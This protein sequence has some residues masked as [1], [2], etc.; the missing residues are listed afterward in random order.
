MVDS[1]EMKFYT[2]TLICSYLIACLC[3]CIK[4]EVNLDADNFVSEVPFTLTASYGDP[5]TKLAFDEDGLGTTW[6]PG[7]K[8]YLVDVA[9]KNKTV[10]L[11]S[12]IKEPSKKASFKSESSVLSGDYVVLYGATSTSLYTSLEMT[13]DIKE[14]KNRLVLYG[15]L[16]V[17]DGQTSANISLSHAYAKLTFKFQN[18]P[19]G[20]T[21]MD[22]G[23]AAS[24]EGLNI[25]TS[26]TVSQSGIITANTRYTKI[27]SFGWAGKDL[28]YILLAPLM[29][30]SKMIYF[31]VNGKDANGNLITYEFVKDGKDLKPGHNYNII[32]NFENAS[33]KSI[34]KKSSVTKY[35]Y[36]LSSPAEFRAAA[37]LN[38]D[39]KNYSIESDVDFSNEVYF[40]ISAATMYGNK[41][42]LSNI[43]INL[44]KCD[45]VGVMSEGIANNLT[46]SNV[47]IKG[48]NFVGGIS[49]SS[50]DYANICHNAYSCI[51]HSINISGNEMVGGLY[52]QYRHEGAS[53]S[54]CEINGNSTIDG[55]MKVGGLI[56]SST[57]TMT[58]C[59]AKDNIAVKGSDSS[60]G[61]LVGTA[62]GDIDECCFEGTVSGNESVGGI[63]GLLYGNI[64]KSYVKGSVTGKS[65][66]IGG[67]IG[68]VS[69]DYS[70][71]NCYVIGDVIG[72]VTSSS[73]I[74]DS[75][76]GICGG[77]GG[78]YNKSG[79][80]PYCYNCYSYGNV[81]SGY[82]IADYLDSTCKSNLTSS[83]RYSSN[84]TVLKCSSCGPN[85]TFLSLLSVINGDEAYS[86]QVW[87]G[88][89]AQCPLLQWQ[90]DL[91]NGDV[92]AP[93][94][95]DEDW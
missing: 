88:I 11:N 63:A 36:V 52:G 84:F 43:N 16:K 27:Q 79:Y 45:A 92:D 20:L 72:D 15:A 69:H 17:T 81:S 75:I 30:S 77:I 12:S 56:G 53:I 2:K 19:E 8:L 94:F 10:T 64:R 59:Y 25:N 61:G 34:L 49:A 58:R 70:I 86:T 54:N 5:S 3:G 78:D 37:Y 14:L 28:G 55:K 38:D 6:Q 13:N 51:A 42:T 9:G 65:P 87:K 66:F 67:L 91:L 21:E 76:G 82:G 71:R 62:S 33:T 44:E 68:K 31:Y 48:H 57:A 40:P 60:I 35:A 74:I 18:M 89:D 4:Q 47:T 22:M 95:G 32:I 93:G 39:L 83:K 50:G 46:I 26:N 29:L 23:M 90:A 73:S 24:T 85:K 7:D 1:M 80:Y 41:H